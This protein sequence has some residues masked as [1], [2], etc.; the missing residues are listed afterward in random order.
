MDRT[1]GHTLKIAHN[2]AAMLEFRNRSTKT[3]MRAPRTTSELRGL[4]AIDIDVV[5]GI[6]GRRQRREASARIQSCAALRN[7]ERIR[8]AIR[9]FRREECWRQVQ[10]LWIGCVAVIPVRES[11]VVMRAT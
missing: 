3:W 5:G 8:G 6:S 2:A 9:Q 11:P 7:Q 1:M 10:G 4:N